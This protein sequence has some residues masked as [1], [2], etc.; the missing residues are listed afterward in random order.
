LKAARI[1][2]VGAENA[3]T[4]GRDADRAGRTIARQDRGREANGAPIVNRIAVDRR[5]GV[6][7]RS[8]WSHPLHPSK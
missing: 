6:A 2:T 3:A 8:G 4:A 7:G 1:L 5:T